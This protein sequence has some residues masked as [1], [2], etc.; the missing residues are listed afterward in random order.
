MSSN[1]G[2]LHRDLVGGTLSIGSKTVVDNKA[3]L[4]AN[5]AKIKGD[6]QIGGT[7]VTEIVDD[8]QPYDVMLFQRPVFEA[9]NFVEDYAES[10]WD[11]DLQGGSVT[12]DMSGNSVTLVS[13]NI[14]GL[15]T[16]TTVCITKFFPLSRYIFFNW[17]YTSA[18][19]FPIYDPFGYQING[20]FHQVTNDLA[21]TMQSGSKAVYVPASTNFTF[22]FNQKS[23]DGVQ[24]PAT[25]V[26]SDFK[27]GTM[28]IYGK[29]I[30]P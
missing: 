25:T 17:N 21:G 29:Y 5:D 6:I 27:V 18:D 11:I 20:V 30:L 23:V 12:F 16:E 19:F 8:S 13:N 9:E 4:R 14:N 7:L 28:K 24:G 3:N 26:I 2:K 15:N 1:H 10:Q 22:C